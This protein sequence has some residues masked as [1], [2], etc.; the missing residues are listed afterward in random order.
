VAAGRW[1]LFRPGPGVLPQDRAPAG[2]RESWSL[3][4]CRACL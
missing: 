2:D 3:L 4:G 1:A